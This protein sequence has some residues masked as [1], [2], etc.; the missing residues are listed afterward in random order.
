MDGWRDG[1]TGR[2]DG[3]KASRKTTTTSFTICNNNCCEL[4]WEKEKDY[5]LAYL[6]QLS[7]TCNEHFNSDLPLVELWSSRPPFLY[8]PSPLWTFSQLRFFK[9]GSFFVALFSCDSFFHTRRLW[10]SGWSDWLSG[11]PLQVITC[12]IHFY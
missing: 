1:W 7:H 4:W 9:K 10:E 8:L 12:D 2:M 6:Q 3:W 11:H 5:M